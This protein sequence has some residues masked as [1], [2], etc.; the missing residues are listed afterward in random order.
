[1]LFTDLGDKAAPGL[2]SIPTFVV[3]EKARDAVREFCRRS[4]AYLS[5]LTAVTTV[6]DQADYTLAPLDDTV[7]IS[8]DSIR[9]ATTETL[10]YEFSVAADF[11]EFTLQNTPTSAYSIIP[12][13]VLMPARD[14]VSF[15]DWIFDRYED[16]IIQ[17]VKAYCLKMENR[18]WTDLNLA[19]VRMKEF[20][21]GIALA[22]ISRTSGRNASE[23]VTMRD[24]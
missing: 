5:D 11:S 19:A 21:S 23:R 8:L 15:P 20:R 13:A 7:I 1:M 3:S 4:W 14:S 24:W 2:K 18:P 17:G 6:A 10:L 22:N 12:K 9:N 16:E